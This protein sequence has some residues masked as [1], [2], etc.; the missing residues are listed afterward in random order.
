MVSSRSS[1]RCIAVYALQVDGPDV[2]EGKIVGNCDVGAK[3]IVYFKDAGGKN[4]L[5]PRLA[6]P[7]QAQPLS[8]PRATP[9]GTEASR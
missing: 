3:R 6:S 2:K 8:P 7:K 1:N 9:I 4:A 5:E